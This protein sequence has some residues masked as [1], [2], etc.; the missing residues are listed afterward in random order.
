MIGLPGNP[1][2]ALVVFELVGIPIV[3]RT[4]GLAQEPP[5]V[6]TRA[7]L[8]VDVGSRSGR[9]DVVQV[10]V[11]DGVAHP[12]PKGSALLSTLVRADGQ[13][14]VPEDAAGLRAGDQVDVMPRTR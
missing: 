4:G 5:R 10:Q 8:A 11:V 12:L 13:V 14:I 7:T 9:L 1:L 2:S 6:T 3:R